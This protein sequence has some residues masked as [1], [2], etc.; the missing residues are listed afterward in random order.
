MLR[1][2]NQFCQEILP[3]VSRTFALSIR[4]LPGDLALPSR[5]AYLLCR[6]A[7]TIE[8]APD[9]AADEKAALLDLLAACFDD[10]A[11]A[12]EFTARVG[13]HH[14]RRRARSPGA[15]FRSRVCRILRPPGH[16]ATARPPLGSRR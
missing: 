1:D 7:D 4:L 13:A 12:A 16:D 9:F 11:A 8:D 10:P 14:R 6:I 15:E 2:V 5:D 3:A